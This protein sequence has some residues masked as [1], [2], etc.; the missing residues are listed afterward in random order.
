MGVPGLW[1]V[2]NK[3]GKST[4]MA[5]L[6]AIDGFEQNVRK[7]KIICLR[8]AY[9]IG[10]DVSIWF[11]HA[12]YSK[13]GENPEL[14]GLFFRLAALAK[15]SIIPL[16]VFDGRQRPSIKR[17]SKLGKSG[18]HGLSRQFKQFLDAFGMEWREVITL[19]FSSNF[20]LIFARRSAKRSELA[21]LNQE[22]HIDAIMT[23]DCD[24]FVFGART[25]VK[26]IS[27]KLSGNK[28]NL[29]T[30]SNDKTDKF[31]AMAYRAIDIKSNPEVALTRGGL[32]LFALLAGGDYHKGVD[33]V[34]K[35]IAHALA[36][37]EFGDELLEAYQN[38]P[39]YEFNEFLGHWRSRVNIELKENK[40]GFLLH[41]TSLSLPDRFPELDVLEKYAKPLNSGNGRGASSSVA[42]RDRTNLD[43]GQI[44]HLCEQHFEWGYREKII[45]RFNNVMW[46]AAVMQ[47]L[48]RAALEVD[49]N[50]RRQVLKVEVGTP[51]SLVRR[52]LGKDRTDRFADAFVNRGP[53][54]QYPTSV[55]DVHPLITKIVGSRQHASTDGTLEYRIEVSPVQLVQITNAG[56]RGTRSEPPP[57]EGG[58]RP[59]KVVD[60][61]S[62]FRI[63]IP[64][65]ILRHVHPTM[66]QQYVAD[67]SNKRKGKRK[68]GPFP[69]RRCLT[70]IPW[71]FPPF[72]VLQ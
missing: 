49:E 18:S 40:R 69:L 19:C 60:P 68:R 2:L 57:K 4:S 29:A 20:F 26:N 12:Y 6:A 43:L 9:R 54:P 31:H 3:V 33:K 50:E 67:Q 14:R 71:R 46:P 15:M 51:A 11:H 66:V 59:K 61:S 8:R 41:R 63:W 36:R 55:V 30:N 1:D 13:E 52:Y 32:I 56:I 70:M 62:V 53:A 38:L 23:D 27:S 48:R 21:F 47:V 42:L 28:G 58:K 44:A 37:C 45:E 39:N 64:A 72:Q 10:I 25:I 16:F 22:G 35:V 5:K 24:A 34:G 17:G 7:V 65:S